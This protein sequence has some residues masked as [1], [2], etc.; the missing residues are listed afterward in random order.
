MIS[1][2]C[3]CTDSIR[4][5]LPS[6]AASASQVWVSS[7]WMWWFIWKWILAAVEDGKIMIKMIALALLSGIQNDQQI[8][9]KMYVYS[10]GN[11]STPRRNNGAIFNFKCK[12]SP[13]FVGFFYIRNEYRQTRIETARRWAYKLCACSAAAPLVWN[14]QLIHL[15]KRP[16][17]VV[18]LELFYC[19][20]SW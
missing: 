15:R 12:N 3:R 20:F 4:Y 8:V 11:D 5:G 16:S 9:R 17:Q 18:S 14:C 7:T 13:T 10:T 2:C 1:R 6:I 19:H